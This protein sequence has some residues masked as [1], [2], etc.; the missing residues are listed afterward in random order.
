MARNQAPFEDCLIEKMTPSWCLSWKELN[1]SQQSGNLQLRLHLKL[2]I[3]SQISLDYRYINADNVRYMTPTPHLL[4]YIDFLVAITIFCVLDANK[5]FGKLKV[6]MEIKKR[7]R[8]CHSMGCFGFLD[9]VCFEECAR[10]ILAYDARPDVEEMAVCVSFWITFRYCQKPQKL[11][12]NTSHTYWFCWT[13]LMSG[14]K[15]G[16]ACSILVR[17]A[18]WLTSSTLEKGII[19]KYNQ[20]HWGFE[21]LQILPIFSCYWGYATSFGVLALTLCELHL[22]LSENCGKINQAFANT[23]WRIVTRTMKSTRGTG[24]PA[25]VVPDTNTKYPLVSHRHLWYRSRLDLPQQ[26][27]SR[28]HRPDWYWSR[29]L[30][31]RKRAYYSMHKIS[32]IG[33]GRSTTKAIPGSQ[34]TQSPDHSWRLCWMLNFAYASCEQERCCLRPY[35]SVFKVL[36]FDSIQHE[37]AH[38]LSWLLLDRAIQQIWMLCGQYLW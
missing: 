4:E 22:Y 33:L 25:M 21:P 14:W 37:H 19:S 23:I 18:T 15:W 20:R 32:C 5:V 6:V 2:T 38:G 27:P 10:H 11:I 7:H 31:D 13:A 30:N 26:N 9:A 35:D 16:N 12:S 29:S 24:R 28:S 1:R 3:C 36:H 17:S 8:S 34:S